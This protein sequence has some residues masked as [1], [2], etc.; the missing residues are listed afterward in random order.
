MS[1]ANPRLQFAEQLQ[2][3]RIRLG[4]QVPTEK[5]TDLWKGQH[6][7]AFMV[8]GAAK[9][10][11]LA[12]LAG[13][14]EG[15][16]AGGQSIEWFRQQFDTI[17][18]KHGWSHTGERNWRTR[19]IYQ[20][21]MSTSYAAGRLAQLRDPELRQLKPYWMYQHND[22]VLH[23]RPLHVS[24]DG[25]TLPADHPWFK[26]HYPPNGWG[27]KCYIT[28]VSAAEA[29]RRGGR[30]TDT[31]PDNGT[32]PNTGAPNGID[33]GWDY[34]P[35]D[36]V[37]G[38][39]A[40]QIDAKMGKLPAPIGQALKSDIDNIPPAP[41]APGELPAYRAARTLKEAERYATELVSAGGKP[42]VTV[43]G[44][45]LLRFRH[46]RSTHADI[47]AKKLNQA[48]YRGM[49]VETAN[50]VNKTLLDMQSEA[51]RLGLPRL[52]AINNNAGRAAGTMGDGMLCI[53]AGVMNT[54]R[55]KLRPASSWR[56][57]DASG[58]RPFVSVGY[59]ETGEDAI[60][61]VL[62]HEFA[63][64]IHQQYAVKAAQDYVAPG[65]EK[66][67]NVLWREKGE[68]RLLPTRYAGTN[69]KEWWAESYALYKL[70]RADLIDEDLLALIKRVEKGETI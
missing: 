19:V 36:T 34:M 28:A 27:C 23:P 51:D 64:H 54:Y 69:S 1:T 44:V 45:P 55:T 43:Q 37:T 46:G 39:L 5:W 67:L 63:H 21:N 26:T 30:I 14:V 42:Y 62:W 47:R 52:R 12:D 3:L 58:S 56:P 6:D 53:S 9:A 10:D 18:D 25:L 49:D 61:S 66:A 15:A 65:L 29:R 57:G 59:F 68:K 4:N 40:R 22:S 33:R 11:L 31:P 2:S 8:A 48:I 50:I 70:G 20:T 35:G 41:A 13:A 24:W 60:N 7:R 16:I 32:D 17:V 38:D